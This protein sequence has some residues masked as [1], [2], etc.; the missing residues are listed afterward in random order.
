MDQGTGEMCGSGCPVCLTRKDSL[1]SVSVHVTG[2]SWDFCTDVLDLVT[3]PWTACEYDVV[4]GLKST[5]GSSK[6]V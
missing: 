5:F 2:R 4:E 6:V 1:G 3:R